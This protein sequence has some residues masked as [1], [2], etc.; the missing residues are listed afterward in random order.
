[1]NRL[2]FMRNRS[3]FEKIFLLFFLT[4]MVLVTPFSTYL[5]S[6]DYVQM[7]ESFINL[8]FT[9]TEIM[10][11]GVVALFVFIIFGGKNDDEEEDASLSIIKPMVSKFENDEDLGQYIRALSNA[12]SSSND[13]NSKTRKKT[14][15]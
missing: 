10:F 2:F 5:S 13:T 14:K 1:M 6:E 7:N 4:C 3:L 9:P 15:K 11:I 12:S 8:S